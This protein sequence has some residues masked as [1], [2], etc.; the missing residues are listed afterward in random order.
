MEYVYASLIL[1]HAGKEITEES[2]KKIL[3]A[4]GIQVDEIRLKALVASLKEIN[5]EEA[6]KTAAV[7]V[8]AAPAT[9]PATTAPVQAK[10]EEAKKEEE[11]K[12]EAPEE[13]VEEGLSSLF[14]F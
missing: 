5:I 10:T 14:G 2:V 13:T 7:P 1:Y 9:A 8:A 6:I 4:A 3:E 12:E 11:K